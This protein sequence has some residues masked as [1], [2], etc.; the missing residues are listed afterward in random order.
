ME[1]LIVLFLITAG[2]DAKAKLAEFLAFYRE[3]RELLRSLSDMMP[4]AAAKSPEEPLSE[5][6]SRPREEVGEEDILKEFLSRL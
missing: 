2:G 5:E 3:N 4:S 6:K 1:A